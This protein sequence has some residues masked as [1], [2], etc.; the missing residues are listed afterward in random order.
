MQVI[1]KSVLAF[2]NCQTVFR[3]HSSG[4][5]P[6][7]AITGFR[8][9]CKANTKPYILRPLI[10]RTRPYFG[11]CSGA[12]PGVP[13]VAPQRHRLN[14]LWHSKLLPR[15]C[16]C[17]CFCSRSPS[18]SQDVVFGVAFAVVVVVGPSN[19]SQYVVFVVALQHVC[20]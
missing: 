19:C 9:C 14:H 15:C 3:S 4:A 10:L 11:V 2:K 1:Y 17:C 7:L 6:V 5:L 13:R 18:C 16:F 20:C 12:S 8:F